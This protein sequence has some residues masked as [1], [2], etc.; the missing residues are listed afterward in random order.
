MIVAHKLPFSL[1]GRFHLFPN[2]IVFFAAMRRYSVAKVR[3]GMDVIDVASNDFRM[4][5]LFPGCEIYAGDVNAVAI[6]RGLKRRPSPHHH[7]VCCDIRALPFPDD[8]FDVSVCTHTLVHVRGKDQKQKALAEMVRV[9]KPGGDL[10]F[11]YQLVRP[12]DTA[13]LMQ[14]IEGRFENVTTIEYRRGFLTWW[15]FTISKYLVKGWL[16]P[17]ARLAKAIS[18]ILLAIDRF[19]PAEKSLYICEGLKTGS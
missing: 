6:E 17:L 4:A 8:R 14:V 10:I 15:E 3:T 11:N 13:A 2:M 18:P 16:V 1:K 12:Q 9:L 19:G 5:W 7:A